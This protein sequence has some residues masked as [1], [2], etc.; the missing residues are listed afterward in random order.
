MD[1]WIRIV[2]LVVTFA[3]YFLVTFA[4]AVVGLVTG[5]LFLLGRGSLTVH[6]TWAR[7]LSALILMFGT[8]LAW[9]IRVVVSDEW[10]TRT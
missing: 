3:L 10:R 4:S 5:H 8:F 1:H 6:G 9:R 2:G 7:I